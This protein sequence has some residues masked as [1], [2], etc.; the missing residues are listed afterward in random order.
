MSVRAGG[1][2][3]LIDSARDT[4]A[5]DLSWLAAGRIA[6]RLDLSG[7][8]TASFESIDG[9]PDS[10][11]TRVYLGPGLRYRL[12]RR[13]DLETQVGIGL[14]HDSPSYFTIG[15]AGYLPVTDA[16]SSRERR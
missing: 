12:S 2:K 10:G 13:V 11:F 6:D 15:I 5:F 1:H 9:T 14:N 8:V 7:G 16:A 3:A 4:S